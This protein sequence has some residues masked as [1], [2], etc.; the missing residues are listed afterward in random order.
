M[1][2]VVEIRG[3]HPI[4]VER[5][6]ILRPYMQRGKV[7]LFQMYTTCFVEFENMETALEFRK[8]ADENIPYW[9]YEPVATI[10]TND[11]EVVERWKLNVEEG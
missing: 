2:Y 5:G 4:A 6:A 3:W 11:P 9:N 1:A 7:Y 8:Y 10:D